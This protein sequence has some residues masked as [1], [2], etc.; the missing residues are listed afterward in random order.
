VRRN[1]IP[2]PPFRTARMRIIGS[3]IFARHPRTLRT[4]ARADERGDHA[5]RLR[6]H[7][8]H[9]R[10]GCRVGERTYTEG[11]MVRDIEWKAACDNCFCAMGAIRCVPLA[12]APP[13]QGCSPI[14]REG[15]CC[16]STYNCSEFTRVRARVASR[17]VF[18]QLIAKLYASGY[19]CLASFFSSL[20]N[21]MRAREPLRC[22]DL[23]TKP[24]FT[25]PTFSRH[26]LDT[27]H[28]DAAEDRSD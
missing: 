1:P 14:V 3:R 17:I 25:L 19:N 20:P 24:S 16:P 10:S 11:E 28:A 13:L 15:Q 18:R 27:L 2:Y 9:G 7:A 12:C 8:S 5:R 4:S 23:L 22:L 21:A 6:S 26:D